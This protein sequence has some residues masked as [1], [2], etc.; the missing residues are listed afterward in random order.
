M[1][2]AWRRGGGAGLCVVLLVSVVVLT[3]RLRADHQRFECPGCGAASGAR[4]S[5]G[6]GWTVG[7]QMK[8]TLCRAVQQRLRRRFGAVLACFLVSYW[9]LAELLRSLGVGT[10]TSLQL[11]PKLVRV[12]N[13]SLV[14]RESPETAPSGVQPDWEGCSL[15]VKSAKPSV[16]GAHSWKIACKDNVR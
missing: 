14:T 12:P 11:S 9:T 8:F 4:S 7:C 3:R 5:S 1:P 2:K 6:C 16:D 15:R 13:R 10:K